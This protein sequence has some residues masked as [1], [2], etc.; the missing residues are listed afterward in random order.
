M[1]ARSDTWKIRVNF[2]FFKNIFIIRRMEFF[3]VE[4][5]IFT[6]PLLVT[7]R[8]IADFLNYKV[9]EGFVLFFILYSIG[10]MIN[11]LADRELDKAYKY[12]LSQAVYAVGVNFIR[13]LIIALIIVAL[14]IA[15]HLS[16]S[17]GKWS[18]LG[19]VLLGMF[20][21]IEYSLGPIFFKSR[22][23]LQ[24]ICLWLLLYFLPMLYASLLV[25]DSLSWSIIILAASYATL[26]MGIILI[27][28]SEDLPEDLSMGIKTT[29][30]TLGLRNT[31]RLATFMVLI[32]GAAFIIFWIFFL[33]QTKP[34]VWSYLTL[35]TLFVICLY[36]YIKIL[37]LS[38]KINTSVSQESAI[39]MIKDHGSVVPAW[40]TIVGWMGIICG[41]TPFIQKYLDT[42]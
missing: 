28:T 10:D 6:M 2:Q 34:S 31:I 42:N 13:V 9:L 8:S 33:L 40:A 41:L 24:L 11:C 36:I 21:G 27:N 4:I 39:K 1:D 22:G 14:A 20:L 19:L 25:Q 30:V 32:G 38:E 17:T 37:R 23:I 3:I 26:E 29:T 7:V 5:T 16:W 15:T 12:R 18:I 35:I